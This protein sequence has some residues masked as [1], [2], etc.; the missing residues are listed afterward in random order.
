MAGMMFFGVRREANAAREW[1]SVRGKVM[2]S[3]V[4]SYRTT[5]NKRRVTLYTPDST[6]QWVGQSAG[7]TLPVADWP[8]PHRYPL[9]PVAPGKFPAR[10]SRIG[11]HA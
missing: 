6:G 4:E 9:L 5:I 7:D 1:L 10:L 3:G 8:V 11:R 2:E